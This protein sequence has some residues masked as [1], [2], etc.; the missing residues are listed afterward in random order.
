MVTESEPHNREYMY[1]VRMYIWY[2]FIMAHS[3]I[4]HQTHIQP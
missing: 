4:H 3:N 1:Y 2:A